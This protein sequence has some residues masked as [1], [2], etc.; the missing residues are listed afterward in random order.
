MPY[1]WF[2]FQGLDN[3]NDHF[4]K[5]KFLKSPQHFTKNKMRGGEAGQC[6]EYST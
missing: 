3:N 2:S 6:T 4:L 5:H 1:A